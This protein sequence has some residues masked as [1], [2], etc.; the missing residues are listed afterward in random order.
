[1]NN[2]GFGIRTGWVQS[3]TGLLVLDKNGNGT[4]DDGSEL[5][6]APAPIGFAALAQMDSN[7][8]G[9][10]DA[11]DAAY[12]QLQVWNDANGNGKVD[13]GELETLAQAGIASINVA[14]T[15]Q[16]GV[17]IAGNTVN[18]V[19]SFTRTDGTSAAIDDV[20][21]TVD[22]LHS[23]YLGDTTVSAAAATM[24][25]LK[26]YGTLTD[27]QV[28]MT[29]DP[30]LIDTFNANIGNLDQLDLTSLRNAAMPIFEAWARAVKL[31]DANGV[32]QTV[33]PTIADDSIPILARTDAWHGRPVQEI[34]STGKIFPWAR[35][36][37]CRCDAGT[38][39]EPRHQ[40]GTACAVDFPAKV[41]PVASAR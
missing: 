7:N 1:M 15:T 19:G 12:S 13:P 18:A 36:P 32:L 35:S 6:G 3:G 37:T 26:G 10:I 29:L 8:D 4:I 22:P 17:K 21:F 30:T 2:T 38:D 20:S 41:S 34:N 11:N 23:T 39:N 14:A 31:P 9:V 28:A 33:D 40:A 16:S 24:A 5:L 25:N 27:L